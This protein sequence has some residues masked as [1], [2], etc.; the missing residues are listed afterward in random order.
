LEA[1]THGLPLIIIDY[2]LSGEQHLENITHYPNCL[3]KR[4]SPSVLSISSIFWK[5]IGGGQD[6]FK[7]LSTRTISLDGGDVFAVKVEVDVG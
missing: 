5:K 3:S 1:F 4:C 2:R 7:L 6:H